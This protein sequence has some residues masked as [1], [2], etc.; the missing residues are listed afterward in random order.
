ML[1]EN[2]ILKKEEIPILH[3]ACF[4]VPIHPKLLDTN[5]KLNENIAREVFPKATEEWYNDLIVYSKTLED[6]NT[7]RWIDEVFLKKKPKIIKEYSYQ[8]LDTLYWRDEI[9]NSKNGFASS[10]SISRNAGGSLYFKR[11]ELSCEEFARFNGSTGYIQFSKDKALEFGF[12]NKVI[13]LREGV[14]GVMVHVYTSHNIDY[15]PGALFLR[16]WAIFY[17]NEAIKTI[18]K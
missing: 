10:L 3:G 11:G 9:F 1:L 4:Q 16:N 17:I 6:R 7:K 14:S 15:Y 13:K 5:I 18:F 12:E 8:M 2:L